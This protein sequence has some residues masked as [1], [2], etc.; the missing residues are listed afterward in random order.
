MAHSCR[1]EPRTSR[2]LLGVSSRAFGHSMLFFRVSLR[3]QSTTDR[4][5]DTMAIGLCGIGEAV[6][7]EHRRRNGE[8]RRKRVLGE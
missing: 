8:E 1:A 4:H 2:P 5:P 7:N 6:A 3:A